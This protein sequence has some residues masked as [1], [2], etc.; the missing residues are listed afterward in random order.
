MRDL[1]LKDKLGFVEN[2]RMRKDLSEFFTNLKSAVLEAG[3]R[4]VFNSGL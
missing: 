4:I 2:F 1:L 3:D